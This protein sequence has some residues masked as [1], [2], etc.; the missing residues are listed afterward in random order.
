MPINAE[1]TN[2]IKY[3]AV[4]KRVAMEKF[5]TVELLNIPNYKP[6]EF[7]KASEKYENGK[8][9]SIYGVL[10]GH[11]ILSLYVTI[12]MEERLNQVVGFEKG[13][14]G[15]KEYA[16]CFKR[17]EITTKQKQECCM[18]DFSDFNSQHTPK[19]QWLLFDAIATIGIERGFHPDW[20]IAAKW[21]RDAKYNAKFQIPN[22]K[23]VHDSIQGMF[24]GTRSTD[25]INTILNKVYFEITRKYL[26]ARYQ[27]YPVNL[28]Q[29]HQGDDVWI[30]TDNRHFCAM[31]FYQMNAFG[32]KFNPSK[33]MFGRGHGEFLRV[34]YNPEGG[35]GYCIRSIINYFLKPIQNEKVLD[36]R[37]QSQALND[38]YHVMHRRGIGIEI[39]NTLWECDLVHWACVK[40]NYNDTG[41]QNIPS[42]LIQL[43]ETLGGFGCP[44]PGFYLKTNI[45]EIASLPVLKLK[46]R[47][48]ED[49]LPLNMTDDWIKYVSEKLPEGHRIINSNSIRQHLMETN[50][51]SLLKQVI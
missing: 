41:P 49:F 35:T 51:Y 8:A 43:D 33:Q 42:W 24:S 37:A 13:H 32:F 15:I 22:D 44:R 14:S 47:R 39:L 27:L 7:A 48:Q 6:V 50:Y 2:G 25:L 38:T 4:N 23:T 36:V 5:T 3:I 40:A 21:I 30:S 28:H 26:A 10:L 16:A 46:K 9:R 34:L 31:L 45:K 17:A 12:G 1:P 18:V 29:V 11:Y 19:S 20:I